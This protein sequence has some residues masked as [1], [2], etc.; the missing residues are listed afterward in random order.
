MFAVS[1]V[2]GSSLWPEVTFKLRTK[3]VGAVAVTGDMVLFGTAKIDAELEP[4][5]IEGYLYAIDARP[6]V[7][8]RVIWRFPTTGAVW[9][10]PV[11]SDGVVYFGDLDGIFHAVSLGGENGTGDDA[12]RELWKFQAGGAIVAEPLIV[13][14][15]IYFGD[16]SD[17]FY[18]LDI[19][20][21]ESMGG[22][23]ESLGAGEWSFGS[24]GWFWAT[25][26]INQGVLYVGTLNGKFY[27]LDPDTGAER[28]AQPG[29]VE[30]QIV[31][32]AAV[33]N[34]V[35]RGIALVVPSGDDNLSVFDGQTG[36]ELNGFAT[37]GGVKASVVVDGRFLYVH[38][39]DDD[40]VKFNITDRSQVSCVNAETG[41]PCG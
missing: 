39:I 26:L 11:V 30:G 7:T 23:S 2:D 4:A 32:S 1:T 5:A 31:G 14:G 38:T 12:G 22:G 21:R 33:I 13:D 25:P 37:D 8:R 16:F 18:A 40:L 6:D 28:W 35:G 9:G 17:T 34:E 27:A 15:K 3:I 29:S 19:K 36:A 20:T 10:T 41:S 24:D